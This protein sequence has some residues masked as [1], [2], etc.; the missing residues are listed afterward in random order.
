MGTYA[1]SEVVI[2]YRKAGTSAWTYGGQ[3]TYQ[4]NYTYSYDFTGKFPSG[5]KVQWL[6]RIKRGGL[7]VYPY[8]W[9]PSKYD[10]PDPDPNATLYPYPYFENTIS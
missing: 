10:Q 6:V 7:S 4:G 8:C 9:A 5:T 3:M 1:P 2:F